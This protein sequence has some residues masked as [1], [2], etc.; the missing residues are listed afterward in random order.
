MLGARIAALRRRA[1]LSQSELAQRLQISASAMGMYE[2][3]RREPS[4]DTL[5][6]IARELQVST[7]FLLTG[8]I[9]T[10]QED[11]AMTQM[12]LSTIVSADGRLA[13]RQERPFSRQELAV[14]FAALLM[15]TEDKTC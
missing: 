9:R 2:Q 6:A 4:V 7:D 3:G 13:R 5:V 1:G 10:V 14:L 8:K 12:L 15:E 11:E